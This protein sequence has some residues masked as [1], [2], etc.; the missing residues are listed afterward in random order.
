MDLQLVQM[1][2]VLSVIRIVNRVQQQ[3][4]IAVRCVIKDSSW[5]ILHQFL[6]LVNRLVV[7]LNMGIRLIFWIQF[8]RIVIVRVLLVVDHRIINAQG[9][10]MVGI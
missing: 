2:L 6:T 4:R 9:V 10:L 7:W 8:A 5:I 3:G 1:E